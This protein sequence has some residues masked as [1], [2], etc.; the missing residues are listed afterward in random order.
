M[1]TIPLIFNPLVNIDIDI[2]YN[3]IHYLPK[4]F[5]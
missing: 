1:M 4:L 3:D 5:Y 2:D